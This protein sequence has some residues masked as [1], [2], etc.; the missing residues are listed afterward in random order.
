MAKKIH[1]PVQVI[2]NNMRSG[3][4]KATLPL[5]KMILLG[6]LSGIFIA[7]AGSASNVAVHNI[8]D[9]GL[10]RTL[11]GV[12]FPVGLIMIVFM[13]GELFT[14]NCL[15]IMNV[16]GKRLSL[17][18]F[19]KNLF[20]IYFSNLL[21][22]LFADFLIYFSGQ[23]NY[24]AGGVGAYTIKVA[25]SKVE[26]S[27]ENGIASGIL[28]NILVCVAILMVGVARETV[29]K[30]FASFFPI[31][32]FVIGGFEHSIANMF[33]IPTGILAAKNPVYAAKAQELYGITTEQL[34]SLTIVNS[35]QNFIPVTIGNFIGGAFVIGGLCFVIFKTHYGENTLEA[36]KEQTDSE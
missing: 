4:E 30:I 27:P 13:G 1:T 2:E 28:C 26:L 8:T 22:A 11:A 5:P 19:F 29:G 24:S 14:S 12:I 25:L 7:L 16:Y 20:V 9:V 3:Y 36:I 6:I 15:I 33:Y 35:L 34:E 17:R 21:G 23:L 10:A 32:A 18:A 31:W